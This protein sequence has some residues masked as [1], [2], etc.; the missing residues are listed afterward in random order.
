M[1]DEGEL[2]IFDIEVNGEQT[3]TVLGDSSTGEEYGTATCSIAVYVEEG[4]SYNQWETV[5]MTNI[6]PAYALFNPFLNLNN[7]VVLNK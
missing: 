5:C 7:D 3:C 6:F 4:K 1:T 2:G